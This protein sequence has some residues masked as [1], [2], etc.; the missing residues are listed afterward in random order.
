MNATTTATLSQLDGVQWFAEVGKPLSSNIIAIKSWRDA[1][2][3]CSSPEWQDV[4]LEGGNLLREKLFRA[5]PERL[6]TWNAIVEDL[7]QTTIPF[8]KR[9]IADVVTA[10]RFPAHFENSVQ[11]D[12]LHVC[13]EA[14]HS[15]IVPPSFFAGLAYWYMKGHFPCGWE[16]EIPNG[17]LMVF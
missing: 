5:A 15:D 2:E 14:E 6:K 1:I 12:I 3:Q 4:Q 17:K 10:Q 8:V 9:K 11:W 16:G 7:K 13:C